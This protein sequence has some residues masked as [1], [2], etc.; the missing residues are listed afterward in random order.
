M[1]YRVCGINHVEPLQI[2]VDE[3]LVWDGF[4]RKAPAKTSPPSKESF[5]QSIVFS[6]ALLAREDKNVYR[7]VVEQEVN[8]VDARSSA[9][10]GSSSSANRG[11]AVAGAGRGKPPLPKAGA[12]AL[13]NSRSEKALLP[14]G[15]AGLVVSQPVPRPHTST[16]NS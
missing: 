1:F 2:Y 8:L 12:Q 3:Q 13:K 9:A 15:N 4:L 14:P 5:V 6:P 7:P 11:G 16:T 10:S